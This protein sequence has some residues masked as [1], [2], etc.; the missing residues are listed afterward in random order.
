MCIRD[1]YRI[2]C[3]PTGEAYIGSSHVLSTR[4]LWHQKHFH[5]GTHTN[6]R[7]TRAI[8]R[9]GLGRFYFQ[10]LELHPKGTTKRRLEAREQFWMDRTD[11]VSYTHLRAHETPE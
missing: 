6:P 3:G 5:D 1:R 8:E 2:V 7:L 9:W 11:T 10:V 4:W